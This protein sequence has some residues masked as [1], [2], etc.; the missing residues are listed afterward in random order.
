[1]LVDANLLLFAEDETKPS[2]LAFLWIGARTPHRSAAPRRSRGC[3]TRWSTVCPL[4]GRHR[5]R[6]LQ[7]GAL[8]QSGGLTRPADSLRTGDT[9]LT[10]PQRQDLPS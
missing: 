4:F 6:A 8:G 7:R 5:L 1:M 10:L 3:G 9:F 2:L